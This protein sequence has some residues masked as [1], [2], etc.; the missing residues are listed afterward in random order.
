[1][2]PALAISVA[3][4]ALGYPPM[5][6]PDG[7]GLLGAVAV[8]I[9]IFRVG[10]TGLISVAVRLTSPSAGKSTLF[11]SWFENGLEFGTLVLG[12]ITATFPGSTSYETVVFCWTRIWIRAVKTDHGDTASRLMLWPSSVC[13]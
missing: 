4:R 12:G 7:I 6:L 1:M 3:L 8:A 2:L 10:N 5:T 13:R 11:G 9:M